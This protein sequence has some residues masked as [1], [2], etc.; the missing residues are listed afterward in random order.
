MKKYVWAGVLV[1]AVVIAAS[2]LLMNK[3]DYYKII[4]AIKRLNAPEFNQT[5]N[6][7]ESTDLASLL[8]EY[9]RRGFKLTC[10]GG[11]LP[12]EKL[13]KVDDYQCWAIIKRAYNIPA[14]IVTFSFHQKK[15][16]S[17]R[18]EFNENS[19]DELQKYL[20]IIMADS[21]RLD[22]KP[23][24]HFGVDIYGKPLMVW[25]TPHGTVTTSG[26]TPNQTNL[27]FWVSKHTYNVGSWPYK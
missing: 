7:I 2:A 16:M 1:T 15:L 22:D 12:E 4:D 20:K 6:R 26:F 14:Q 24:A 13:T 9:E 17:V 10:Y 23:G 3:L 8:R 19:F 25:G 11:L 27:V 21:I 18:L 5:P